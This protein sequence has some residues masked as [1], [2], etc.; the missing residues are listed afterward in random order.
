MS[1]DASPRRRLAAFAGGVAAVVALAV[2]LRLPGLA[3]P[4]LY[5]DDVWVALF[6]REASLSD[7][8]ALRPH[9][10]VGF[11]LLQAL[12]LRILPGAELPVQLIPFAASLALVPLGAWLVWRRGGGVSG[13]I[14]AAVVVALNPA[15]SD[16]SVRAKPYATDALLSLVLVAA[17]LS[18]L[19]EPTPRRLSRLALLA[20]LAVLFSYPAALVGAVG[21]AVAFASAV[22]SAKERRPF[23]RIGGVF[24]A[25]EAAV[26]LLFV[27]GQANEVLA[28]FWRAG[29]VSLESV[30]DAAAFVA[31]RT[32]L[33]IRASFPGDWW[34][35]GIL[36]PL[37]L[38]LL[39]RR[40]PTRLP[41]AFVVALWAALF[42]AAAARL[43]P[44]DGRTTSFAYPLV[45]LLAVWTLTAQTGRAGSALV[46]EGVPAFL[47][48][49]VVLTSG[50]SV[51]YPSV[52]DSRLVRALVSEAGAEDAVLLYPH[53]NWAAAYYGDWEVRLA[54]ADHYATRFEGRILRKGT[55]TL[56]GLPAY[57]ER[58]Q[59]FDPL[60]SE[61]VAQ[62]PARV[63]YLAVHLEVDCCNAHGH[64]QRYLWTAG[65]ASERLAAGP[66]GELI[67][68][69][70]RPSPPPTAASNRR[71]AEGER[72]VPGV[73]ASAVP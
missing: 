1:S 61:L 30:S 19:A 49:V 14:L 56:P 22:A 70:V 54:R 15:L 18:S 21:F 45:A 47:A 6:A 23:F 63:L 29:F 8:L 35:L 50:R 51:S 39:L 33:V 60:L 44:V 28:G 10:P 11:M 65:Y 12:A 62:K 41:A 73:S 32:V 38:A 66:G 59:V 26:G 40:R 20:P 2:S 3:P 7:L 36:A 69:A 27:H 34:A 42:A 9:H 13:G 4:S 25:T 16:T 24:A 68:F 72:F 48:A 55:F 31:S 53:A 5:L 71:K 64:V 43:Y 67:R 46:R 52:E 58:P 37:G 17:T 57:E